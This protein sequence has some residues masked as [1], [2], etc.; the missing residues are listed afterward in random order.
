MYNGIGLTTP[1]GSGT[2]GYVQRNMAYMR[3]RPRQKYANFEEIQRKGPPIHKPPNEEIIEHEKKR[4]I[5][6]K[7]MEWASSAGLLDDPSI[8]PEQLDVLL[9]DRREAVKKEFAKNKEVFSIN[10]SESHQRNMQKQKETE[11]F[12][13]ALKVSSDYKEGSAFDRKLQEI[14][15]QQRLEQQIKEE[16]EKRAR[17]EEQD[18]KQRKAEKERKREDKE[19]RHRDKEDDD[20]IKDI[21]HIYNIDRYNVEYAYWVKIL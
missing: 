3:D 9:A 2:N 1:R 16:F 14:K 13:S 10:L 7:V 20:T 15:K 8:T 5:E 19:Q 18:K 6:A 21:L 11:K 12:K 17:V 4:Q